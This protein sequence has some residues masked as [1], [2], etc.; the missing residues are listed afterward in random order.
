MTTSK[1]KNTML[2]IFISIIF[3][4]GIFM[5]LRWTFSDHWFHYGELNYYLLTDKEVRRFPIV[6]AKIK[7]VSYHSTAQ[8]GTSAAST[9]I[10][11]KSAEKPQ[12]V[13]QVLKKAGKN[14]GYFLSKSE[15]PND[16]HLSFIGKGKYD[17]ISIHAISLK[18]G[19]CEVSID[20][21]EK[22]K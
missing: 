7:N 9:S 17:E 8:D 15:P 21:I 2:V 10:N 14:F 22:L 18:S 4:F 3:L 6:G 16:N 11:Y 19:G 13:L 12:I 20:F 5:F 1:F